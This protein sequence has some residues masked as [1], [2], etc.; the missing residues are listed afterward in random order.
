MYVRGKF[1]LAIFK[2]I[3]LM[4]SFAQMI[5]TFTQLIASAALLAHTSEGDPKSSRL[6]ISYLTQSTVMSDQ[7]TTLPYLDHAAL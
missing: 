5:S 2:K 1:S 4:E 7:T 3:S 6:L